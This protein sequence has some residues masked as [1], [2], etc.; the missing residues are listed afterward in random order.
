MWHSI[1]LREGRHHYERTRL[2]TRAKKAVSFRTTEY[3]GF[4]D[5]YA[6]TI[7]G[8]RLRG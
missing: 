5:R 4:P 2:D 7:H 6:S 3:P 8:S 1:K